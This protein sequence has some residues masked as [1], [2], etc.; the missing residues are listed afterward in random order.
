MRSGMHTPLPTRPAGTPINRYWPVRLAG[1][2]TAAAMAWTAGVTPAKAERYGSFAYGQWLNRW[3]RAAGETIKPVH[4]RARPWAKPLGIRLGNYLLFPSVESRYV[5]DDNVFN[6]AVRRVGDHSA[7]LLPLMQLRSQF[8]R[9]VLDF[10]F[11]GRFQRYARHSE[12]DTNDAF[13]AV[14]GALH[15]N[16]AY[17]LTIGLRS[18]LETEES[19]SSAFNDR[20]AERTKLWRNRAHIGLTRDAGRAFGTIR[21]GYESRDYRDV[22][23]T[24]GSVIDQDARDLRIFS[25]DVKLGYRFSPKT[26]FEMR[27]RGIRQFNRGNAILSTDAW[28][29]E[30]L[31]GVKFETSPILKWELL[32]G[33]GIRDYDQPDL[34]TSSTP[35]LQAKVTWLPTQKLS[36]YGTITRE[37][38][39]SASIDTLQDAINTSFGIAAEFEAS[40]NLIF[41]IKGEYIDTDYV[42]L[43]REERTL[44]GSLKASYFVSRDWQLT[45]KYE[46]A[47]R[48]SNLENQD[49]NRNRFMFG[50]KRLF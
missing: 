28:G 21:L 6:S 27:F 15:I 37:F 4:R 22:K 14:R 18:S 8:A 30:V 42:G 11:G 20:A 43:D 12:L 40:R 23:A 16:H 49:W 17:T 47:R 24:D 26:S 19:F 7:E 1:L 9:H 46:H 25:S 32:G 35:L 44:I 48:T 29:Y 10:D 13:G 31:A 39:P 38:E 45:L 5:Y 2:A 50:V 34:A 41:T 36:I 3:E 33:Y